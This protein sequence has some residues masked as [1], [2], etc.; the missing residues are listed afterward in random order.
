M[1]EGYLI[2]QKIKRIQDKYMV[3]ESIL[4]SADL[5]SWIVTNMSHQEP[6]ISTI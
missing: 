6:S 5:F 1:T 4:K 3:S 2:I